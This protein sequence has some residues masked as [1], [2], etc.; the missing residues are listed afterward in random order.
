[1][2]NCKLKEICITHKS[3]KLACMD[4]ETGTVMVFYSMKDFYKM[5]HNQE[6]FSVA[7][8]PKENSLGVDYVVKGINTLVR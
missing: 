8:M 7:K 5:F 3:S 2:K 6:V 4:I 1:M